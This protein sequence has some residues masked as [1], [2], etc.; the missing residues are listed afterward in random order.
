MSPQRVDPRRAREL[1]ESSEHLRSDLLTA[2]AKLDAYIDELKAVMSA[3][4]AKRNDDASA[5]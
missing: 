5:S 4:E 3:R 1:L 2:V